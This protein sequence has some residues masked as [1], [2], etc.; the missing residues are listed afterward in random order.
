MR[1]WR[2]VAAQHPPAGC[3]RVLPVTSAAPGGAAP[4]LEVHPSRRCNLACSHC[5]T[6]SGPQAQGELP[7][8]LLFTALRDA[9]SL[10]YQQL[11][12]SGGEPLLSA[13]LGPLLA[14]ARR[15]DLITSVTTNGMMI[16]QSRR[17][18]AVAPLID[19][20]SISIDG[21]EAEHDEL[22]GRPGAY[23]RTVANLAIAR[24]TG[25]EFG[26]I[27]TLTQ[28]NVMSLESVVALAAREGARSVQVH[29]L[30]LG[31][32][33]ADTMADARPDGIELAAAIIE[34]ER[35]GAQYGVSVQVDAVTQDQLALYRGHF[36]PRHGVHQLPT[37]APVLVIDASGRVMPLSHDIDDRYVVGSLIGQ[38]LPDLAARWLRGP[39]AAELGDV[40]ERTWWE[41]NERGAMPASHWSDEIVT[42]LAADAPAELLAA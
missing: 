35:L 42:R 30:T 10:G 32:R 24:E 17:W 37:L 5:S 7:R 6:S 14:R 11:A 26:L 18:R 21:T 12:V 38:R 3:S 2:L 40:C 13:D 31:G 15:L 33:A 39:A 28:F 27:F 36:V 4:V 1:I 41:L 16:N 23:A 8:E 34:A 25:V 9:K 29:P 19:M 22:R 20:L